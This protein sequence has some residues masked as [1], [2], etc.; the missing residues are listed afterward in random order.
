MKNGRAA[1]V[2]SV[3]G[4]HLALLS[5]WLTSLRKFTALPIYMLTFT[6]EGGRLRSLLAGLEFGSRDI[7]VVECA[8]IAGIPGDLASQACALKLSAWL[9]VPESIESLV[10]ADCDLIFLHDVVTEICNCLNEPLSRLV[11]ARDLYIGY[12]EKMGADFAVLGMGWHPSFDEEGRRRYCNTGLIGCRRESHEFFSRV[13]DEWRTYSAQIGDSP[14]LCDQG[15]LNFCLD[16]A[17]AGW[18][19]SQVHILDAGF[20]AL[21]EYDI[22]FDLDNNQVMLDQ[23]IVRVLHFNG[24]D[25]LQKFARRARAF[26]LGL[27]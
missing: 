4:N 6:S 3:V 23:D 21:K 12:K 27:L 18:D 14:P 5:L 2:T 25:V 13:L 7:Y 20:N 11:M 15:L 9:F 19:W 24:G 1:I 8:D 16:V 26:Q 17:H 10:I 22:V